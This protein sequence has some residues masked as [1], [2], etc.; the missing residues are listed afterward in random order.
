MREAE[1]VAPTEL[2]HAE[3]HQFCLAQLVR[4]ARYA[5]DHG[6][7][8]FPSDFKALLKDACTVGRRRPDLAAA[9]A[10]HGPVSKGSCSGARTNPADAEGPKLRDALA[11]H[12]RDKL[13][14]LLKRCGAKSTNRESER[15]LRQGN[16]I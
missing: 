10:V 12:C 5:I 9:A 14:L 13:L 6:D 11:F 16:R 8:I 2:R 15:A 4:D 7:S 1:D 3:E